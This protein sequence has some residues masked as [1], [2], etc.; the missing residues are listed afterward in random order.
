MPLASAQAAKPG[1]APLLRSPAPRH[2]LE[3]A[4]V[5]IM[6]QTN[7]PLN[8]HGTLLKVINMV[9][10]M[11]T[12]ARI[13]LRAARLRKVCPQS[14]SASPGLLK[15]L[16]IVHVPKRYRPSVHTPPQPSPTSKVPSKKSFLRNASFSRRSGAMQTRRLAISRWKTLWAE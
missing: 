3:L 14:T 2:K 16:S 12:N 10:T 13:I 7:C 8:A 5:V 9:S 6:L 11:P 4:K 15:L 1:A